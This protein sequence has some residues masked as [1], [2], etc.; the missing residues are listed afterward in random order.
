MPSIKVS[1]DQSQPV[2]IDLPAGV[3]PGQWQFRLMQDGVVIDNFFEPASDAPEHTFPNVAAGAYQVRVQR[4]AVD[5]SK[6]GGESFAD[7]EVPASVEGAPKVR[8]AGP[9]AVQVV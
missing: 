4:Y 8:V 1:L 2:E 3:V 9:L 6:L 5:G 7:V